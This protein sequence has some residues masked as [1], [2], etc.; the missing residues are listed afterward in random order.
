MKIGHKVIDGIIKGSLCHAK[1][2]AESNE[3]SCVVIWSSGAAEQI[4][5]MV[6]ESVKALRSCRDHWKTSFEHE[7]ENVIRLRRMIYEFHSDV[8]NCSCPD[9]KLVRSKGRTRAPKS[10]TGH[11]H[12]T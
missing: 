5:A 1:C 10:Q 7:R 11:D 4:E 3:H 2:A 9:C 8:P 6:D 12:A